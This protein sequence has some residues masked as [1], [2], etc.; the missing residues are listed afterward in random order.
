MQCNRSLFSYAVF[1]VQCRRW[2]QTAKKS[3]LLLYDTSYS[4]FLMFASY[5]IEKCCK[6]TMPQITIYLWTILIYLP[7]IR[8]E[9]SIRISDFCYFLLKTFMPKQQRNSCKNNDTSNSNSISMSTL[10]SLSTF[11]GNEF[12]SKYT[13]NP[14]YTTV[15]GAA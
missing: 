5:F 15:D 11:C 9:Q 6:N 14:V 10:K 12:D 4:I 7:V 1:F 8:Y 2:L 3:Y 13:I